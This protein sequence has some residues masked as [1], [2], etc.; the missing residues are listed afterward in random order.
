MKLYL[1]PKIDSIF[2]NKENNSLCFKD[3]DGFMVEIKC[4]QQIIDYLKGVL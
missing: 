4:Y 3:K 2:F 1:S